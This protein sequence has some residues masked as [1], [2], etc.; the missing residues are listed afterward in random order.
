VVVDAQ[1]YG[2][3]GDWTFETPFI[4]EMILWPQL[5]SRLRRSSR[6]ARRLGQGRGW[7]YHID[8]HTALAGHSISRFRL[9]DLVL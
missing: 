9:D 5:L 2:A 1:G 6:A 8:F 3:E 7:N 4:P